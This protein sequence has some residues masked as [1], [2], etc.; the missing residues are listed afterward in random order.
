LTKK[1]ADGMILFYGTLMD[2]NAEVREPPA[3]ELHDGRFFSLFPLKVLL[4]LEC[5]AGDE[6][7][8]PPTIPVSLSA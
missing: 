1:L 2:W 7:A 3:P 8:K 5:K 4:A 6:F